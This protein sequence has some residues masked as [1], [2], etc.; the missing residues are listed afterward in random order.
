ME[1]TEKKTYPTYLEGGVPGALAVLMFIIGILSIVAGVVELVAGGF[2]LFNQ[3]ITD[4]LQLM[5]YPLTLVP[6]IIAGFGAL[7]LRRGNPN[8]A[9]M[10]AAACTFRKVLIIIGICA[11]AIASLISVIAIFSA[12]GSGV[13]LVF[14]LTSLLYGLIIV[15]LVF[16]LKL[17]NRLR[18]MM[19]LVQVETSEWKALDLRGYR[20]PICLTIFVSR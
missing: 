3:Y 4:G 11:M 7:K 10:I 5:V 15:L 1:N 8:G 14:L 20:P 19:N 9:G 2:L 13:F 12:G 17:Y 16:L 18:E 6:T